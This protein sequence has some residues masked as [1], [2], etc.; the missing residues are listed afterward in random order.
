M[1]RT[2]I[3]TIGISVVVIAVLAWLFLLPKLESEAPSDQKAGLPASNNG[4]VQDDSGKEVLYWYDPMVP[5]QR[6]DKPGKSPFMDMQLVP[7]YAGESDESA[8]SILSTTLQN[9]AIRTEKVQTVMFGAE[10][11]AVGRIE[12][13]ERLYYSIQTRIPGFVDR[14]LIRAVGDPVRKNQKVA[15]IYAPELLAA[16]KEYLALLN[17]TSLENI[18]RLKEAARTR[19]KLLGMA[20]SEI[21]HIT[22]SGEARTRIGVYSP[23]A[24]VLAELGVREGEELVS[25]STLMQVIDLSK[26]WV[27]AEVPERDAALV[28]QGTRTQVKLQS[29]PGETITGKVGYIYPTLNEEA[30]TLRV[31]IELPNAQ[32]L[33]IPGMYA[34][35]TLQPGAREALAVPSES[36]I[37][38]GKRKVVI[39]KN[40]AGF[41]PVEIETGREANGKTEI[42]KGLVEGEMVVSSGQFLIDSEASL[43]GVLDRLSRQSD[44]GHE[45]GDGMPHT[46]P[47]SQPVASRGVVKAIDLAAREVTLAHEPIPELNWP[48]MTMGFEVKEPSQL[49]N[50]KVGDDVQFEFSVVNDGEA[51]LIENISKASRTGHGAHQ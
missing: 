39:V 28:E 5:K 9:L 8:V 16:Q 14:L 35:V 30:R 34:E 32:R 12:P 37:A 13:D 4:V 29:R 11:K 43:S 17:V 25:G 19:L 22:Q 26:V 36:V 48:S 33:L 49:D 46:M 31:R 6:F 27:I 15:E 50:I 24:G 21:D 47:G 51:Y 40:E 18:A 41:R 38:T 44:A 2:P 3:I 1:K 45:M 42:L 7:K 10:I 20:E 23:I